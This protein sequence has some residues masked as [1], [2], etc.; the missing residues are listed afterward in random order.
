MQTQPVLSEPRIAISVVSHGQRELL[1]TLLAQLKTASALLPMQV[2][3]TLN[4]PEERPEMASAEGFE[5]VWIEN[6]RPKGFAENHNAAFEH[7]RAPYFCVLNPDVR[8]DAGSLL[9]LLE[10]L[11]RLP[12]VAGPRVLSLSGA[13][14]DNA[15]QL[16]SPL[17]LLSRWWHRRFE[18]DYSHVVLEQQVDWMAGMCLAFDRATYQS[19]GGFDTRYRLYCEDIDICLKVHLTCRH[20]T[21]VQAGVV[22]HDAQRASHR[23]WRYLVWH[24]GSLLKLFNS[25]TYWR[26]R[27]S[28]R[29]AAM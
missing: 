11:A 6:P 15:R 22:I 21:W 18:S 14:E 28:R 2:I 8:L 7:C 1:L 12:G 5:V 29:R 13:L 16:P 20:V 10:C 9:P 24:I 26:F 17:R 19:I 25:A 3:L 27:F 4:L 23:S